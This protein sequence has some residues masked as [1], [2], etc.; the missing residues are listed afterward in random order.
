MG[1]SIA[2]AFAAA[3]LYSVD[4][5]FLVASAG[6]KTEES[7]FG[8]FCRKTGPLGSLVFAAFAGP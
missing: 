8:Q 1:G 3:N 6:I 2:T 7:G 5:L 4:R